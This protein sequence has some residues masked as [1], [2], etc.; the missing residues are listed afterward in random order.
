[1]LDLFMSA[2]LFSWAVLQI[3][4]M[5]QDEALHTLRHTNKVYSLNWGGGANGRP[6]MVARSVPG[7]FQRKLEKGDVFKELLRL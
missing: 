2:F 6:L 3:W 1:M 4:T 5:Q 7:V